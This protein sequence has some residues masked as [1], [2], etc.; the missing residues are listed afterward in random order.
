M[1]AGPLTHTERK[2]IN[3][4]LDFIIGM[5]GVLAEKDRNG[6]YFLLVFLPRVESWA[7]PGAPSLFRLA[8]HR[9]SNKIDDA[10]LL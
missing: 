5:L 3:F 4:V 9:R 2:L 8:A 6:E 1:S 10:S 7:G